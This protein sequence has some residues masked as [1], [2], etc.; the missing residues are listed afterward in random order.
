MKSD[1]GRDN[2]TLENYSVSNPAVQN[3]EWMFQ[4]YGSAQSATENR[5]KRGQTFHEEHSRMGTHGQNPTTMVA[6]GMD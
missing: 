2:V 4:M 6:E 1:D 5:D 3:Q